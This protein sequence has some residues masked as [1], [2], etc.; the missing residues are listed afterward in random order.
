MWRRRL[1][2]RGGSRPGFVWQE[3]ISADPA[4][5]RVG[6]DSRFVSAFGQ[7]AAEFNGEVNQ[8]QRRRLC[9]LQAVGHREIMECSLC[10]RPLLRAM[11]NPQYLHLIAY[12]VHGDER[13]GDKYQFAGPF[14]TAWS[15]PI[16]KR[17]ETG[18]AL[19]Y[20]LR[21]PPCGLGTALGDVVADPFEIVRGVCRLADAHQPR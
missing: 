3:R 6:N 11:Q 15:P 20:G 10:R 7:R 8:T 4:Q 9:L 21:N 13:K 14:D 12:L 1:S 2:C 5:R 19:D 18:D 17:V 16:W